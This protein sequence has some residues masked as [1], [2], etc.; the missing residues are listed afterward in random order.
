[1]K[2]FS[3]FFYCTVCAKF[4][5]GRFL[6]ENILRKKKIQETFFWNI[7]PKNVIN[8]Q[9]AKTQKQKTLLFPCTLKAKNRNNVAQ[10]WNIC[11]GSEIVVFYCCCCLLPRASHYRKKNRAN[12]TESI[13]ALTKLATT[14]LFLLWYCFLHWCSICK[15]SQ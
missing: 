11:C 9:S 6:K 7:A 3:F 14:I 4:P 10:K 13:N 8:L 12:Q 1:M 15:T 5:K 2:E